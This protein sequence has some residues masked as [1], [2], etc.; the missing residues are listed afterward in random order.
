MPA[1]FTDAEL[2]GYLD[3]ALAVERMTAIE[4]ALRD[5]TP[6]RRRA[7]ELRES[8]A[9]QPPSVGDVWRSGR[10]TCP[11][12]SILGSHLLGALA[13]GWADYIDFHVQTIGCRYCAANL[14][15][16]R[17]AADGPGEADERRRKFFQSSA[18]YVRHA[19]TE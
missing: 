12:R 6:L 10:L 1:E 11:S 9:Q 18:G 4:S 2:L 3:E 14:A 16:L 8:R 19:P 13:P 7:A 17:S 15:D 5:S